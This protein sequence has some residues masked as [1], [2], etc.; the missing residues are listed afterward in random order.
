MMELQ[1]STLDDKL[2][3]HLTLQA[4]HYERALEIGR[5]LPDALAT[6]KQRDELLEELATVSQ[7]IARI[8]QD[9]ATT[10]QA[11]FASRHNP[12][13]RLTEAIANVK[14]MIEQLVQLL[15][16]SESFARTIK[17]RLTPELDSHTKTQRMRK[18]YLATSEQQPSDNS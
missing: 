1:N 15:S 11:Y 12:S 14:N 9:G 16:Q 3:E 17:D 8:D 13:P 10:R 5:K 6:G 4:S 18:A 7:T 2:F